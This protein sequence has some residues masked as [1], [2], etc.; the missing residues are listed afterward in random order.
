MLVSSTAC[1]FIVPSLNAAGSWSS[2]WLRIQIYT[3]RASD[4]LLPWLIELCL[5]RSQL[6]ALYLASIEANLDSRF[7]PNPSSSSSSSSVPSSVVVMFVW[8]LFGLLI[9]LDGF[10]C[11]CCFLEAE[12]LLVFTFAFDEANLVGSWFISSS[13][14]SCS[15]RLILLRLWEEEVDEDNFDG[16][17]LGFALLDDFEF[18][19][20]RFSSSSSC[21]DPDEVEF[22]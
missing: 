3:W 2:S 19:G 15:W 1:P 14:N 10:C 6:T 12:L 17:P 11:C 9:E 16:L 8:W 18:L 20:F 4:V 7:T 5:D 13:S 21:S 22:W